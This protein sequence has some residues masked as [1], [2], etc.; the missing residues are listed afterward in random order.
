MSE[1][2]TLRARVAELEAEVERLRD[3]AEHAVAARDRAMERRDEE[4]NRAERAERALAAAGPAASGSDPRQSVYMGNPL[5][6]TPHER[7]RRAL[8]ELRTPSGFVLGDVIARLVLDSGTV[9]PAV[10]DGEGATSEACDHEWEVEYLP[11]PMSAG[12]VVESGDDFC[13]NCGATQSSHS[14]ASPVVA[15]SATDEYRLYRD[16]TEGRK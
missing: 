10:S 13:R 11:D 8:A 12:S 3:H 5:P 14:P 1:V 6:D 2:E 16:R 4:W 9:S 7:A 15:P